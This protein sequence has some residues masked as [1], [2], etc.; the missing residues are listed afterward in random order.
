[1]SLKITTKPEAVFNEYKKGN[2]YKAYIGEKGIFEQSKINERFY[3]GDQWYGA[4]CGNDK[5]LIRQ[6]I[7]K[8][9]ADLKLSSITAAPIAVNYRADGVPDNAGMRE[10]IKVAREG[11]IGGADFT[12]NTTDIEISVITNILSDYFGI[13]AERVKF[14][15]K[16]E[17]A[18]R[19]AYISGT[20]I[21]YTY[22]DSTIKTGL[23]ADEGKTTPINGD[24]AFEVLDVENVCFGDP[25]C[26][27][28]Q[29]QPFIIVSQRLDINEVRREARR[30]RISAEEIENIKP[31]GAD[32]YNAN[33]GMRGEQEPED[34]QRVT[35]LTKFYRE[36]DE[37]GDGYKV[38][39][40]KVCEKAYVR[41]PWDTSLT[42]Y[43]IAKMSWANRRSSIYGDSDITYQIPNQI[44]LNRAESAAFWGLMKS[45]M[46]MTIVNGDTIPD[47][48]TN[49]PGEVIKVYGTVEDVA[50][51][52]R[53][54]Q[55]PAF[56][57]QY[58]NMI[59]DLASNTLSYNGANEAALG[60]IRPDNAAAIIQ[61]REASLQPIQLLQNSFYSFIEDI[62]KIWADFWMH[63]YGERKL[64]VESEDG[65][66]YVPFHPE[67]YKN[68]ILTV[69][70][71]V[72]S[73]PIW[74]L[75]SNIAILDSLFGAQIIDKVDYLEN[76]PEGVIPNKT[77]ILE[78]AREEAKAM[79]MMP[80]VLESTGGAN[81]MPQSL[82]Q[83]MEEEI[84]IEAQGIPAEVMDI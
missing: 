67:R 7:I 48:I 76:M 8:R 65:T 23:Y 12:G 51:A 32:T 17:Q 29:R 55:P 83:S 69:K 75:P 2:E 25:N 35:V 13:S 16:K 77:K 20:G 34:S 62:A 74:S 72:G 56:G 46:P 71:D 31:D 10:D 58:I 53:H 22:W 3:V 38:M 84:P 24:I 27:D 26:D 73:G 14:D 4:Q 82:P 37:D 81:P 42:L 47:D 64:R 52:I 57:S 50:G 70:I 61:S 11:I 41:K 54:I 9:I 59:N 15:F 49:N 21:A 66:Y 36:W 5:P 68:L 1:M 40:V 44:A 63:L 18:L 39:A 6:N 78:K 19:N 60:D 43:P 45:G 79:A 28:V 80:T 30:N 33:A